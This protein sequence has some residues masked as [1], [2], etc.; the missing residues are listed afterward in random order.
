MVLEVSRS[1]ITPRFSR[2]FHNGTL[3]RAEP[4]L[5]QITT[6]ATL[7]TACLSLLL[8]LFSSQIFDTVFNR[9]G[10]PVFWMAFWLLAAQTASAAL[11]P[12][13]MALRI[14]GQQILALSLSLAAAL[15][16]GGAMALLYPAFGPA[17]VAFAVFINTLGFGFVHLALVKHHF[18][19]LT[20]ASFRLS[21]E[22]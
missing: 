9:A 21:H 1:L 7:T 2:G 22:A 10:Q 16:L 5:R 6:L 8:L 12:C 20:S 19:I 18:N 15:L 4:T 14:G 17:G 13:H 11:G 3:P